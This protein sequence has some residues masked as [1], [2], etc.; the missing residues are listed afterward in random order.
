M[1][2]LF[3]DIDGVV[4]CETS[5]HMAEMLPLDREMAFRVGKIVLETDCKIVLSSSWRHHPEACSV[6]AK[7]IHP[8]IDVTPRLE[9]YRRGDEIQDWLDRHPEVERYAVLDDDADWVTP[10]QE[11]CWFLTKWEVGLTE[12][13]MEEVIKHLNGGKA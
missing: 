2:I 1:K 10:E 7:R 9:T 8:F 13:I 12:K 6:I 4:N 5:A 3:L 11:A